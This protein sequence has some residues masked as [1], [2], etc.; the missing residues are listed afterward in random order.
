MVHVLP[1]IHTLHLW[2]MTLKLSHTL[3]VYIL[4]CK[5]QNIKEVDKKK[6]ATTQLT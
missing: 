2:Y 5:D 1:Q 3:H 4:Y 6:L